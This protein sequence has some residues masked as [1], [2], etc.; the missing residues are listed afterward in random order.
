[1]LKSITCIPGT[2][3]N[4]RHT[5]STLAP[6]LR[7]H[8]VRTRCPNL[9][10]M[11]AQRVRPIMNRKPGA[12]PPRPEARHRSPL[13]LLRS[14]QRRR[15][16]CRTTSHRIAH[17]ILKKLIQHPRL[18]PELEPHPEDNDPLGETPAEEEVLPP[19][20]G[21]APEPASPEADTDSEEGPG[22]DSD[23]VTHSSSQ[24]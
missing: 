5:L 1:M 24:P 10:T 13:A 9:R 22:S 18:K 19:I 6:R 2:L 16:K 15:A 12:R 11:R 8:R 3:S 4:T 20:L 7:S 14:N 23:L 17:W 21:G